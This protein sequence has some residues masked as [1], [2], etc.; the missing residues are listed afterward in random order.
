MEDR[1]VAKREFLGGLEEDRWGVVERSKV[2]QRESFRSVGLERV[3][4]MEV[5]C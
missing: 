1:W 3:I 5:G 2:D 4:G